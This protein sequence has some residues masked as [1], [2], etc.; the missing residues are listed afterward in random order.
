MSYTGQEY[1]DAAGGGDPQAMQM[2]EEQFTNLGATIDDVSVATGDYYSD[3]D[4][5]RISAMRVA[6]ADGATLLGTWVQNTI[7]SA[8]E[9]NSGMHAT[10]EETTIAGKPVTVITTTLGGSVYDVQY[11]YGLDDTIVTVKGGS[12]EII[13]EAFSKLP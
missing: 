10:A 6:G 2:I 13:N 12:E 7:D 4:Y 8:P 9:F 3:D 1:V 11:I 5:V